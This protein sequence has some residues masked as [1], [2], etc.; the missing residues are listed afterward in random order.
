MR[1]KTTRQG[2]S[3]GQRRAPAS[4]CF[5]VADVAKMTGR[6]VRTLRRDIAAG[7]LN[8]VRRKNK[9]FITAANARMWCGHDLDRSRLW[10]PSPSPWKFVS[11]RAY[12]ALKGLTQREVRHQIDKG[13]EVLKTVRVGGR[14]F[15][16]SEEVAALLRSDTKNR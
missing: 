11:I 3:R 1:S 10:D 2:Q 9:V 14:V 5:S 16:S 15:I 4:E 6:S 12:A 7:R 8:V 13:A